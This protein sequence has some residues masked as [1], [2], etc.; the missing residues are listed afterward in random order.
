MSGGSK[1]AAEFYNK[2]LE[3][4]PHT[5][6]AVLALLKG[7]GALKDPPPPSHGRLTALLYDRISAKLY[8]YKGIKL[9]P[10]TVL[11]KTSAEEE[12]HTAIKWLRAGH[13][14]LTLQQTTGLIELAAEAVATEIPWWGRHSE[15]SP[16]SVTRR[17]ALIPT[18]VDRAF[19]G[20][21][22]NGLL[23]G[24]AEAIGA[25]RLPLEKET[26]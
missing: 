4:A 6:T 19:P 7:T 8:T 26:E 22:I 17:L 3:L 15:Q 24:V 11:R 9:P 25:G 20:Y 12:L 5:R 18:S 13:D 2:Y 16:G 10:L 14:K 1:E 23:L 21:Q